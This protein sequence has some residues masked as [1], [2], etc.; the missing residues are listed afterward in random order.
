MLNQE[1]TYFLNFAIPA[2]CWAGTYLLVYSLIFKRLF[3][4]GK[5]RK[6]A[7]IALSVLIALIIGSLLA[8][9]IVLLI[10]SK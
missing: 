6:T 4:K 7:A 8:M 1:L 5:L 10:F 3:L 2:V 9:W